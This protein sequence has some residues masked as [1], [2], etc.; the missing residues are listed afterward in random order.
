[1]SISGL[2]ESEGGGERDFLY[3]G[4]SCSEVAALLE[5]DVRGGWG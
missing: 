2:K 1:M 3:P 5:V 4:S